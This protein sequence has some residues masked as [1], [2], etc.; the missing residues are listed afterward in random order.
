VGR[1]VVIALM[2]LPGAGKSTVAEALVRARPA[3][4]LLSRDALRRE[5][6][7]EP[8]YDDDEKRALLAALLERLDAHLAAGRSV[9]LDGLTLSR[10]ADRRAVEAAAARRGARALL[11]LVEVGEG[12]ARRR[13][14]GAGGHL[15]ADRTPDLVTEVAARFEPPEAGVVRLDGTRAPDALAAQVLG[16]IGHLSRP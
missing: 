5:L 1:A 10:S 8:A 6:I 16:A 14:A 15:A 3:L 13:I 2:G 4:V 7:A 9:V 12:E 11:A